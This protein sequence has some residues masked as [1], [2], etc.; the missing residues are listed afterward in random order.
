MGNELQMFVISA[1]DGMDLGKKF[2]EQS[3]G[4][5]IDSFHFSTTTD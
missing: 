4:G 2:A 5:P 1:K 3:G